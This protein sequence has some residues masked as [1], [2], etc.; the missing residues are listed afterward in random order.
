MRIFSEINVRL[1]EKLGKDNYFWRYTPNLNN[2]HV[3]GVRIHK[4]DGVA[5]IN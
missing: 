1:I 5:A 4:R 3:S 2:V